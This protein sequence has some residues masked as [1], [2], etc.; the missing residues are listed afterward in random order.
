MWRLCAA[1]LV[2]QLPISAGERVEV[3]PKGGFESDR[4][5]AP[6]PT[7]AKVKVPKFDSLAEPVLSELSADLGALD[8]TARDAYTTIYAGDA[9]LSMEIVGGTAATV[10]VAIPGWTPAFM[11]TVFFGMGGVGMTSWGVGDS[12]TP[13]DRSGKALGQLSKPLKDLLG[14]RVLHLALRTLDVD[15]EFWYHTFQHLKNYYHPAGGFSLVYTPG[16]TQGIWQDLVDLLYRTIEKSLVAPRLARL[17]LPGKPFQRH[18]VQLEHELGEAFENLKKYRAAAGLY[19]E[20]A[21]LLPPGYER[22]LVIHN[23]AIARKRAEDYGEAELLYHT[24]IHS[25]FSKSSSIQELFDWFED[26]TKAYT[27]QQEPGGFMEEVRRLGATLSALLTTAGHRIHWNVDDGRA[28]VYD[29]EFDGVALRPEVR[30]KKSA[31]RALERI[32]SAEFDDLRRII[33]EFANPHAV[34]MAKYANFEQYAE[35]A[36]L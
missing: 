33:L 27:A 23:A 9:T 11:A 21:F 6:T 5:R 22:D 30:D 12:P 15:E 2:L 8:A 10:S 36:G 1:I 3:T 18:I 35:E 26:L 20:A 7:R 13:F 25:R 34:T 16:E 28:R 4:E 29:G 19:E 17:M 24:S 14:H 31:T 32:A